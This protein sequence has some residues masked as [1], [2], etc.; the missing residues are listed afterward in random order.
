MTS[1]ED[2]GSGYGSTSAAVPASP[3]PNVQVIA[4][5][6]LDAGYT[7]DAMYDGVTFSV[8]VPE[9][10]VVKGQRFIVPFAPPAEAVAVA[11]P[12]DEAGPFTKGKGAPRDHRYGTAEIPTGVWRDGL[13]D[14]CRHGCCHPHLLNSWCFL[15][16][17]VGQ[18]LTRM[19]MTWLGQRTHV[20]GNVGGDERWRTTFRNLALVWFAFY[21]L[22]MLTYVPV[23]FDVD[24]DDD[25][26]HVHDATNDLS[27]VDKVKYT[28]NSWL[29]SLFGLYMFYVVVQLRATLRNVYHIPEESCLCLYAD[30]CG[31]NPRD[32]LCKDSPLCAA[33]VPV[34]WEDVCCAFWC[35]CCAVAQMARHTVDYN[36]RR[37]TCCN[38]AI[39][40][41]WDEDEA[42][43]GT[44][45]GVG[46]GSVLV[47]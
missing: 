18:V 19:K 13:C 31:T 22:N 6:S 16:F 41:D 5:A 40:E 24:D 30:G 29:T 11:V 4:P 45:A 12:A 37:A 34:G 38:D 7:F 43:E 44:E 3:V 47:V 9:G 33:N 2:G 21:A 28:I 26:T 14:C 8:V 39:V 17:M 25:A 36:E 42:Y 20:R 10:G 46:E 15:P 32:G 27:G 1:T 35:Q 23:D